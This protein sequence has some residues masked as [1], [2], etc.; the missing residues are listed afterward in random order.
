MKTSLFEQRCGVSVSLTPSTNDLTDWL[1]L[2]DLLTY[3]TQSERSSNRRLRMTTYKPANRKFLPNSASIRRRT[4]SI[5]NSSRWACANDACW[6][7]VSRTIIAERWRRWRRLAYIGHRQVST[8]DVIVTE[9]KSVLTHR[10]AMPPSRPDVVTAAAMIS[11][12]RRRQPAIFAARQCRDK[13]LMIV[14]SCGRPANSAI[15][16]DAGMLRCEEGG[17]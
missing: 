7:F 9:V 11:C 3:L 14:D 13:T 17:G 15:N 10:R 5:C 12:P 6:T 2:T 16:Y 1:R 4:N 8:G